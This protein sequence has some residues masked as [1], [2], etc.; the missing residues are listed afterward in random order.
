M[1]EP[2]PLPQLDNPPRSGKWVDPHDPIEEITPEQVEA[3]EYLG[4][5][6]DIDDDEDSGL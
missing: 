3:G 5:R 4:A 2:V 6:I 1:T